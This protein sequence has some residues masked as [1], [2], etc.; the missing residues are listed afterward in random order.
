MVAIGQA[1]WRMKSAG[2][3][4]WAVVAAA[5][6]GK[7]AGPPVPTPTPTP[8]AAPWTVERVLATRSMRD[9]GVGTIDLA[10][11]AES[12]LGQ[13]LLVGLSE[14]V[15]LE[16][17]CFAPWL[18]G[19]LVFG[20]DAPDQATT[21]ITMWT[22]G[23]PV[24]PVRRCIEALHAE[25]PGWLA[26]APGGDRWTIHDAED[27]NLIDTLV[28]DATTA[29][30]VIHD[31]ATAVSRDDLLTATQPV[32]G[33]LAPDVQ[34]AIDGIG[35]VWLVSSGAP[36]A[37]AKLPA[38][39]RVEGT[40]LNLRVDDR[41]LGELALRAEDPAAAVAVR[42]EIQPLAMLLKLSG[43]LDDITV[44]ADGNDVIALG[45]IESDTALELV[46]SLA[47]A[48]VADAAEPDAAVKAGAP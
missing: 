23:I 26:A 8:A 39:A 41:I 46:E 36:P 44:R 43:K 22:V 18:H 13:T 10:A 40:R 14:H 48:F 5:C 19:A 27:G 30:T 7:A 2:W 6:G 9:E 17:D 33:P 47:A 45:G 11:I 21:T 12:R 24:E 20:I 28:L 34:R 4:A 32:D 42:D 37:A 3:I 1:W 25:S 38:L 31:A 15:D 29:V 16:H 35:Q